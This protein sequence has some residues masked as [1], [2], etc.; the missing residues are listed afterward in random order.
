MQCI[1]YY[2]KHSSYERILNM[3]HDKNVK[4]GPRLSTSESQQLFLKN[5]LDIPRGKLT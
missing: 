1:A 3:K 4:N 5:Y 2:T